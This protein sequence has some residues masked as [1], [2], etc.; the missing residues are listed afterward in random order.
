[1]VSR[2]GI[3]LKGNNRKMTELENEIIEYI[4]K[5]WLRIRFGISVLV[6]SI[7]LLWLLCWILKLLKN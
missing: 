2:M 1:M 7:I 3:L 6:G 5:T 4:K